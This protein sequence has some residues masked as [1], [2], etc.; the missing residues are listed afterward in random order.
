MDF[1]V[2]DDNTCDQPIVDFNCIVIV[3][4]VSDH[5]VVAPNVANFESFFVS[6]EVYPKS[7]FLDIDKEL[8]NVNKSGLH[9]IKH[10]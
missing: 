9:V 8:D 4:V 6:L 7:C 10:A 2:V 3:I 1:D 5:V